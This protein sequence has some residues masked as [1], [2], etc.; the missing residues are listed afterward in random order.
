[1][2]DQCI[3]KE[4]NNISSQQ[5]CYYTYRPTSASI[6]EEFC[7]ESFP[8]CKNK[9]C[10]RTFPFVED[11]TTF[12]TILTRI[13]SS[14]PGKYQKAAL[15]G[16]NRQ[17][18]LSNIFALFFGNIIVTLFRSKTS[19]FVNNCI[20]WACFKGTHFS[21]IHSKIYQVVKDK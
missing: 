21:N 9:L 8:H 12:Q 3:E 18:Y 13:V 20:K 15:D 7:F 6:L 16:K 10:K 11:K 5:F 2:I 14:V 4:N 1:M 17:T 19:T